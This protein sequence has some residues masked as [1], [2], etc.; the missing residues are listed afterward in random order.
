MFSKIATRLVQTAQSEIQLLKYHRQP[1]I[2]VRYFSDVVNWGDLL[3]VDII[4]YVSQKK[5]VNCPLGHRRHLLGIGSVLAA[6]N[7]NSVVWGSGFISEQQRITEAP[8]KICSVRGPLT[9]DLLLKQDLK[10]PEIFG[11]PALLLPEIYPLVAPVEK[12]YQ[13]GIIPHYEHQDHP[14]IQKMHQDSRVCIIDIRQKD[15]VHFLQQLLNCECIA[16]S[17]LHGIIASDAYQVPNCRL[18]FKEMRSFKFEDYYK[19]VGIDSFTSIDM[20]QSESLSIENV[21]DSCSIKPIQ[22]DAQALKQAFPY[23]LF[24]A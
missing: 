13:L 16:S 19:G 11:D 2:N 8:R 24:H 5:V 17:S 3:N 21:I 12:P 15:S 14:W 7:H 23:Q 1:T 4:Q 9:R 20:K 22:F 18:V 10:C 6:S